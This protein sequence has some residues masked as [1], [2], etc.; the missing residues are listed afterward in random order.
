MEACALGCSAGYDALDEDAGVG[1]EA[2]LR[3]EIGTDGVGD[4]AERGTADAAVTGE[5]GKDGFGGVDGYGKA[6]AGA[7]VGAVGGDHGVDADDFSVGV[8]ERAAGVAG[9]DGGV[10]LNGV[11]NGRAVGV[12]DGA[13]GAD[14][15]GGHGAGEAEG[16]ADGVDFLADG[17]FGRV[18]KSDGL[19]VG[20]GDLQKGEVVDLVLADDFGL[21]AVFVAEH[22]PR[23]RGWLPPPRDSW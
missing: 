6:D 2:H 21:V 14:D 3:G 22:R 17:E 9:V 12:A 18:G 10:G 5:V 4:D 20:R 23:C 19:E 1:G 13:D 8:E 7:L 11:F 16:V 15:A